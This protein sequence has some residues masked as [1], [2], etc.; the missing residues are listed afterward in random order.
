LSFVKELPHEEAGTGAGG[1]D[2][3]S[4]DRTIATGR[5]LIADRAR[6]VRY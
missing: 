2:P 6:E 4:L 3:P 1:A 5:H